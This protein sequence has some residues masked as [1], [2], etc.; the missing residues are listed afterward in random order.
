M[1]APHGVPGSSGRDQRA[2]GARLTAL[3]VFSN[4]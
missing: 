4:Q 1:T 3:I 2:T